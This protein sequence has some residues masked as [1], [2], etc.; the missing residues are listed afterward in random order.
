MPDTANLDVCSSIIDATSA[1]LDHFVLCYIRVQIFMYL[2]RSTIIPIQ[3]MT[4]SDASRDKIAIPR[5]HQPH[6]SIRHVLRHTHITLHKPDRPTRKEELV[7]KMLLSYNI[8]RY[9]FFSFSSSASSVGVSNLRAVF[10]EVCTN[11]SL[12]PV[13]LLD[14][15]DPLRIY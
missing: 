10:L 7:G 12:F 3:N 6:Q 11:A 14:I 1:S 13:P 2:L 8:S 5:Q 9:R 15:E 4:I